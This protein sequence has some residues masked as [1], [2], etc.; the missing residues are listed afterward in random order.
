MI[1]IHSPSRP[2]IKAI[3]TGALAMAVYALMIFGTLAHLEALS[4]LAPFDM[5]PMG[6]DRA[7]A[8]LLLTAL[9]PEGR[10]YYLTRQIP[11]DMI[12]P[13]LFAMTLIYCLHWCAG[14]QTG[15]RLVRF[16]I[17]ASIGAAVCDYA[18]NV[19]IIVMLSGWPGLTDELVSIVSIFTVA[20]SVLT[21]MAL[22]LV[23]GLG[24][25]TAWRSRTGASAGPS[26]AS[27][28]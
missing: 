11:L 13:G 17:V 14:R 12:Y 7:D 19:G 3:C 21:T 2:A 24:L 16:G 25:F 4:G 27:H 15:H 6:F 8:Q 18:E 26:N 28:M 1:T 5:R 10:L 22:C 23:I 9:G 20:K